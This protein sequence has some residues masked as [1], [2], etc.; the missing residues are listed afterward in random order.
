M[1]AKKAPMTR[2]ELRRNLS[3]IPRVRIAHLPTPLEELHNLT[4]ALDGPRILIKRDDATGLAFGGNKARHYE[5]EIAHLLENGY[6]AYVNLMD[7][8]SNNARMTAAAANKFGIKYTC[9]LRNARNRPATGNLL[10]D[11]LLGADLVLLDEEESGNAEEVAREQGRKL[12]AQGYKPYVRIEHEYPAIVGTL[13]YLDAGLE[14]AGQLEDMGIDAAH[15]Y[16]VAGRSTGGLT[17]TAKN[18]GLDWKVTGVCVNYDAPMDKYLY[19]VIPGAVRE[20]ALPVGFDPGDMEVLD[21]YIGEGYGI[22][23]PEVLDAIHLMGRTESIIVDP[24]YTGTVI[25]ALVDQIKKGNVGKDETIVI[26][27]TGGM[28]AVFT[29]ADQLWEHEF[30]G[31]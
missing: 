30:R 22:P 2:A 1:P 7:Y 19:S 25:A 8:H 16:G 21:Q 18:L 5:F 12:E 20:A 28:P 31:V 29:F 13:A 9:V 6:D 10:V 26:L 15:I 3:H 23:T 17:L 14:L 4:K 11:K 24:N 27:H